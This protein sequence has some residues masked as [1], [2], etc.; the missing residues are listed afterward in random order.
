MQK[1][2]EQYVGYKQFETITVVIIGFGFTVPKRDTQ[3]GFIQ[4]HTEF[5]KKK[6][7][8]TIGNCDER[9]D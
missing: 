4:S 2:Y 3:I 5:S 6:K 9:I 8:K 7:K 1:A